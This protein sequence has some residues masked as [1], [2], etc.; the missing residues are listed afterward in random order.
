[1]D[2][3]EWVGDERSPARPVVEFCGCDR[4]GTLVGDVRGEEFIAAAAGPGTFSA[5]GGALY[6]KLLTSLFSLSS[7]EGG[8][9]MI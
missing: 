6:V 3:M 1:M 2:V 8:D 7:S 9:I 5:I 4:P